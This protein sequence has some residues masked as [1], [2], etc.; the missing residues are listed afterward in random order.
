MGEKRDGGGGGV[1]DFE[2]VDN[3]VNSVLGQEVE[4]TD[5]FKVARWSCIFNRNLEFEPAEL[6]VSAAFSWAKGKLTG[7][8]SAAQRFQRSESVWLLQRLQVVGK[9]ELYF[10]T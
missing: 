7:K 9:Q 10:P 3:C 8:F 1:P 5:E 4:L 6:R 2:P